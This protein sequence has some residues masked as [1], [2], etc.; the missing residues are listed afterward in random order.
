LNSRLDTVRRIR[1][2]GLSCFSETDADSD[3]DTDP[4]ISPGPVTDPDVMDIDVDFVDSSILTSSVEIAHS[5][6]PMDYQAEQQHS[7]HRLSIIEETSENEDVGGDSRERQ[8]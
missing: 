2:F 1:D 3:T 8:E 7:S 4:H 5:N 6:I